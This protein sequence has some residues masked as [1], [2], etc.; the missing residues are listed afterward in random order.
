MLAMYPESE[1]DR[2]VNEIESHEPVRPS[3]GLAKRKCPPRGQPFMD[4]WLTIPE[5]NGW[6][7]PDS[8]SLHL[9]SPRYGEDLDTGWSRGTQ[10]LGA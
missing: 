6:L 7:Q 5:F 2:D 1:S 9:R 10:I 4:N 8:Q 3:H